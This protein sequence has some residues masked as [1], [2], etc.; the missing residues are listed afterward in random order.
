MTE[1]IEYRYGG[2]RAMVILHEREL[3]SFLAAWKEAKCVGVRLPESANPDYAS[4]ETLLHHVLRCARSYMTWMCK[5]SELPDPGIRPE[6][7]VAVVAAE[8]DGYVEHL[9]ERWR[10][11][12]ASVTEEQA[13]SPTFISRWGVEYCIDAMLEHAV[14]HPMRHRFQLEELI[15]RA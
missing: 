11:P 2:V 8:A 6:P 4:L 1:P 7:A 10:A 12:L 13:E 14:M 5:K 15:A 3:R 9:V